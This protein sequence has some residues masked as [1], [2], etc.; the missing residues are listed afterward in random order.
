M[1]HAM[2]DEPTIKHTEQELTQSAPPAAEDAN[3]ATTQT[4]SGPC[5]LRPDESE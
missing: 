5:D 2:S 1:E 3:V 4:Y